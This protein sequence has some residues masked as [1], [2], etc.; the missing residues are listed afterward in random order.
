[1]SVVDVFLEALN[2][3][4]IFYLTRNSLGK[5]QSRR[6]RITE[7]ETH[8]VMNQERLKENQKETETKTEKDSLRHT[9]GAIK[10]DTRQKHI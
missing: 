6:N 7:R 5:K 8:I 1:M 9:C 4:F 10:R 2:F 3:C